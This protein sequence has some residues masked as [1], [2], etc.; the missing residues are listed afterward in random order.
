MGYINI[1]MIFLSFFMIL[2][3]VYRWILKRI[4]DSGTESDSSDIKEHSQNIPHNLKEGLATIPY[5]SADAFTDS[6]NLPLKEYAIKSSMNS[7]YDGTSV[8]IDQLAITMYNGYRFID[9]NVFMT[10]SSNLY[11]G[12]S[13]DNAP[14]MVDV[15]LPFHKAIDYINSY[16]FQLDTNIQTKVQAADFNAKVNA[17]MNPNVKSAKTIQNTYTAYPLFLNIRV[18][19]PPNSTADIISLVYDEISKMKHLYVDDKGTAIKITQYTRLSD[20]MGKIIITMDIENILQIY[21]APVPYDPAKIPQDTKQIIDKMVSAKTG[22]DNWASFYSYA[23]VMKIPNTPLMKQSTDIQAPS[24]ETNTINLK[25]VYPSYNETDKNPDTY[26][27]LSN[28]QIQCIPIR[29]YISDSNLDKYVK[30]FDENKTPFLSLY[31]ADT[32][33]KNPKNK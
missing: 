30:L 26:D 12:F 22:G 5:P 19:R 31:N 1:I 3:L 23:D 7:T 17:V 25:M 4:P 29:S 18:Y 20:I 14:T 28:H 32:F 16:A 10:D 21:T 11:V 33:V 13:A 9:L 2:Y 15:S 27:F 24:Y 8:S 6:A